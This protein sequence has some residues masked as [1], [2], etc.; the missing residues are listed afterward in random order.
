MEVRP[1]QSLKHEPPKLVTEEGMV[2]EVRPVQPQKHASPKLVTEEGM[3]ME[4][5]PLHSEKHSSPKLVTVYFVPFTD[6]SSGT[7][8]SPVYLEA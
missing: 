8:T 4:V 2:M 6:I 1:V 7:T 5:R 3:V